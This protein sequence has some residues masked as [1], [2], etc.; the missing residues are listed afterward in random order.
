MNCQRF[1]DS[2]HYHF[3]R[4]S[5]RNQDGSPLRSSSLSVESN[6]PF[7]CLIFKIYA[8]QTHL[9]LEE[10]AYIHTITQFFLLF[11]PL[12]SLMAWRSDP[13]TVDLLLEKLQHLERK[14]SA[15]RGDREKQHEEMS[16]IHNTL[17]ARAQSAEAQI[18][19]LSRRLEENQPS[20]NLQELCEVRGSTNSGVQSVVHDQVLI[21]VENFRYPIVIRLVL[22]LPPMLKPCI[23]P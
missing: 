9:L 1:F 20:R 21:F 16:R 23:I 15:S 13:K 22:I 19:A 11:H 6:C 12:K 18:E 4:S 7:E 17:Q 14:M 3:L 10:K 5:K 2:Y 8:L